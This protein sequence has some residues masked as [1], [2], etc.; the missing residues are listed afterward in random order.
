M[1]LVLESP[2]WLV[3]QVCGNRKSR[4][5]GYMQSGKTFRRGLANGSKYVKITRLG[6]LF[7]DSLTR[8]SLP[9]VLTGNHIQDYSVDI[10]IPCLSW[11]ILEL[12]PHDIDSRP[13]KGGADL[14]IKVGT[15]FY[16][17]F[18]DQERVHTD[19]FRRPRS[20]QGMRRSGPHQPSSA[21]KGG[22]ESRLGL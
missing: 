8:N 1:T 20:H 7:Q 9:K 17:D 6:G 3:I 19:S 14:V 22:F 4:L 5:Q 12:T 21:K 13:K 10:T 2:T 16:R 18:L 11:C 15:A